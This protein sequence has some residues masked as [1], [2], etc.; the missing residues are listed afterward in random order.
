MWPSLALSLAVAIVAYVPFLIWNAQ[1]GWENFGFTFHG[2]QQ[3]HL[4]GADTIGSIATQRFLVYAV[5]L[6]VLTWF[7]AL[8]GPV[9]A[10]LVAW[11]ALPLPAGLFVLAATTEIASYWLIGPAVSLALGAGI[12]LDRAAKIWPRIVVGALGIG[13]AYVTVAALFLTLPET[14]QAQVYAAQPA[15]R[16]P[17]VSGV[18]VFEP[19]TAILRARAAADNGAEILADRYE[20][21]AELRF[22][23]ASIRVW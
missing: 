10:T 23:T 13:T 6:A 2:R 11:T 17:F 21:A 5:L 22:G 7:I 8:R 1:H 15:L 18:Y 4:F 19:L 3:F 12:V 16:G 14:A 20:T 9:R